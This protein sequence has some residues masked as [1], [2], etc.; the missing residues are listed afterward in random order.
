MSVS[1]LA[2]EAGAG[3]LAARER[4]VAGASPATGQLA[5]L[6]RGGAPAVF[7]MGVANVSSD[8][9]LRADVLDLLMSA[10]LFAEAIVQL[11]RADSPDGGERMCY[12]TLAELKCMLRQVAWSRSLE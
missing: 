4:D 8:T 5:K 10:V 7:V 11:D 6:D 12:E 1:S 9:K 3:V 2:T